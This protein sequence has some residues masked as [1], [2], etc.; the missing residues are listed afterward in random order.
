[1]NLDELAQKNPIF[2]TNQEFM[3]FLNQNNLLIGE[4]K[5]EI[6]FQ[7]WEKLDKI[8]LDYQKEV[9]DIKGVKK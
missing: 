1:M 8:S 3:E 4:N 2:P 5:D 9:D 7:K 6:D